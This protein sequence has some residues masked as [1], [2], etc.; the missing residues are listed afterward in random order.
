MPSSRE[1]YSFFTKPLA[2]SCRVLLL[3][4]MAYIFLIFMKK[5]L[6]VALCMLLCTCCKAQNS[7]SNIRKGILAHK[8]KRPITHFYDLSGGDS[9]GSTGINYVQPL[10]NFYGNNMD[11][12]WNGVDTFNSIAQ[13]FA[14]TGC[15]KHAIAVNG[16][17]FQYGSIGGQQGIKDFTQQYFPR[18]SVTANDKDYIFRQ[19]RRSPI[20]MINETHDYVFSRV[21]I[22]SLLK[23]FRS[24]G[25]KYLAMETL[26]ANCSQQNVTNTTGYYSSEPVMAELIRYAIS[27][28]YALVPYE[29]EMKPA[30]TSIERDSL[31]ALNIIRS[32][33][34][35]K[36]GKIM[37]IAGYDHINES[38]IDTNFFWPMAYFFKK[39]TGIDP[40]TIE[41]TNLIE[42][43]NHKTS[44]IIYNA[45]DTSK[46]Q[47]T[48][49]IRKEDQYYQH[50]IGN[51]GNPDHDIYLIH[52]HT[53]YLNGRP[54]W[55][56]L[57]GMRKRYVYHL[58]AEV[59]ENGVLL[60]AYY[61]TEA[62]SKNEFSDKV[63][64]DQMMFDGSEADLYLK[65]KHNYI[66]V[67][68][69]INNE[70][71]CRDRLSF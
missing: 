36:G 30:M 25:Y 64:A 32:M 52:P 4:A 42:C 10:V 19:A 17:H 5:P 22:M 33:K 53:T 15:Y 69:D 31:E 63:P 40:F 2:I 59:I 37:V 34:T 70:I 6:V 21:Y 49:C 65:P 13:M 60:Q 45:I 14:M 35:M 57:N 66:I 1:C 68:R 16:A 50:Y 20:T 27:L 18:F 12:P 44:R 47:H 67:C 58:P 62:G 8:N 71:I 29:A 56:S 9:M 3:E 26:D 39:W 51:R 46:V 41:Q 55:L 43:S 54:T 7:E 11:L 23:G 38:I 61:E 48:L 28:G 24:N